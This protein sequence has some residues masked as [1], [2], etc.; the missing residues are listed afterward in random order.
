[1][2]LRFKQRFVL[3]LILIAALGCV[4]Q[5]GQVAG[6]EKVARKVGTLVSIAGNSLVVKTDDGQEIKSVLQENARILRI[7]PGERDLKNAVPMTLQ[8]L[9]SGDRVLV[10]IKPLGEASFAALSLVAIKQTDVAQK[11]ARERDEWQK[12]G[13][14]GIVRSKDV[15]TGEITIAIT[16]SYNVLV[17]T[18]KETVFHIYAADSIRFSDAKPGAFDQVHVGDQLRAK[19]ARSPDQKEL[20]AEEVISGV[21][22][23]LAGTVVAVDAANGMLTVKDVLSKKTVII[24]ITGDSRLQKLSPVLAQNIASLLK[25]PQQ[26]KPV[27]AQQGAGGSEPEKP[28]PPPD[29]QQMISRAPVVA[30]ADLKKDDAVIIVSTPGN[31]SEGLM[32]VTLLSG[33]ERILTA[34]PTTALLAGWNLSA[35]LNDPSAQ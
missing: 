34:A 9:R 12:R 6:D 7:A 18:S 3:A 27:A 11:Q 15:G 5:S 24:K 30:L 10:V 35:A 8:E 16:P 17:K 20:V 33:V 25:T 32:A 22:R 4:A 29:V 13:V 28:A 1:M 14:G 26:A 2:N 21:F 31:G 19:G 23:N